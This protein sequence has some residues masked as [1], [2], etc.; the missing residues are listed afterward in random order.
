MLG[1][2][3]GSLVR[4]S[5][6]LPLGSPIESPNTEDVLS[7]TLLGAFIGLWFVSEAVGYWGY[8]H[9]LVECHADNFGGLGISY[10]PPYGALITSTMNSVRCLSISNWPL[11]T[12]SILIVGWWISET[13]S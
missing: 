6:G 5:L 3:E 2:E 4:L 13:G 12:H 10:V 9:H 8:L 1:T 7:G 11:S